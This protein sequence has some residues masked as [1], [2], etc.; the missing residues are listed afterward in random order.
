M[1]WKV[2]RGEI[3]WSLK[4]GVLLKVAIQRKIEVSK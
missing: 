2:K 1:A 3:I 4:P